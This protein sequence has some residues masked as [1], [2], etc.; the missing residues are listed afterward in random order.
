MYVIQISGRTKI[1]LFLVPRSVVTLIF[2]LCGV[3]APE[4]A[5]CLV[6]IQH[7]S[8]SK[9]EQ[10]IILLQPFGHILM[11]GALGNAEMR[12][13]RADSAVAGNNILGQLP[14]P[15]LYISVRKHHSP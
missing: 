4:M 9:A 5:L 6:Y 2:L 3:P 10:A 11:H 12:R 8:H 15:F 7:L 13:S 1:R 14:C